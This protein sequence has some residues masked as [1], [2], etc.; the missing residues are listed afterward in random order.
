MTTHAKG[1]AEIEIFF[2]YLG[3]WTCR[4]VLKKWE[5]LREDWAGKST[6]NGFMSKLLPYFLLVN[7]EQFVKGTCYWLFFIGPRSDQSL[8]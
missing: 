6:G 7:Q 3:P 4:A 2:H 8:P 5:G 1:A